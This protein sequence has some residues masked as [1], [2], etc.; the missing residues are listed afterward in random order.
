MFGM[1]LIFLKKVFLKEA[2]PKELIRRFYFSVIV[3]PVDVS[4]RDV[5]L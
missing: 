2:L 5:L 3:C 1:S 4:H